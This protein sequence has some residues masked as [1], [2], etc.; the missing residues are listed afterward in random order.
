[1]QKLILP[2]ILALGFLII[3]FSSFQ[4]AYAVL[5]CS[6]AALEANT[7]YIGTAGGELFKLNGVTGENCLIGEIKRDTSGAENPPTAPGDQPNIVCKDIAI[8][9]PTGTLYCLDGGFFLRTIGRTVDGT[10]FIDSDL[11]GTL[12]DITASENFNNANALEI[13]S[14]GRA[15]LAGA[16]NQASKFY[17]LDLTNAEATLRID[18]DPSADNIFVSSGDLA[19]DES[20]T[21]HMYQ[22]IECLGLIGIVGHECGDSDNDRLYRILLN[23]PGCV[24]PCA[25]TLVPLEELVRGS[26]FALDIAQPTQNLCYLNVDGWLFETDRDGNAI[27]SPKNVATGVD[28]SGTAN[29]LLLGFGASGNNIG[30]TIIM[31]NTMA[32]LIAAGQSNPTWLILLAISGVAV[33]AYQFKDKIKSKNKKIN[34]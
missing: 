1:M 19:R 23:T 27:G 5:D 24:G 7:L 18:F 29:S 2:S 32:L 26:V 4:D 15:Y 14:Q 30:G 25:D 20:T 34:E 11:V 3:G 16:G 10:G 22:T 21:N 31:I 12:V 8:D 28:F 9:H 17:T 13:D 6:S 33:V